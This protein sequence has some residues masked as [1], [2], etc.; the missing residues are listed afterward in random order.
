MYATPDTLTQVL[1][2]LDV[3]KLTPYSKGSVGR[4]AAYITQQLLGSAN[5]ARTATAAAGGG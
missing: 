5:A 1:G 2:R 3:A 4:V